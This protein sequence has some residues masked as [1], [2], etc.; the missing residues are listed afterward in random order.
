MTRTEVLRV[1]Q[2][3]A[4]ELG[5]GCRAHNASRLPEDEAVWCV[6][7]T[8]GYGQVLVRTWHGATPEGI[9][10]EIA[11]QLLGRVRGV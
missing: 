6:L 1:A 8:R 5:L 9:K 10:D 3:A 4:D 7:F 11:R 2:Q